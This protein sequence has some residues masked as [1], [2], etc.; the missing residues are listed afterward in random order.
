[1]SQKHC[2]HK[3]QSLLSVELVELNK[4]QSRVAELIRLFNKWVN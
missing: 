2:S 3:Q 1:M 4:Q